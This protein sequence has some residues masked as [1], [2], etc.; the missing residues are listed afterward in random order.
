MKI[1]IP[2][3]ALGLSVGLLAG[4]GGGGS[5]APGTGTVKAS[6]TDSPACGYDHVYV[7][8]TQVSINSKTDGSGNWNDINLTPPKKID[9]LNLTNGALESL[10]QTALP[11]GTYQQLR[12]VLAPNVNGSA[13]LNNSVV[14][15]GQNA[16]VAL[17]TPSAAQS[18]IKV[19]TRAPF[20]VQAGTLV[21]LVLDFNACKS[22]V[23]TG[24]SKG[25]SNNSATGFLLKPVITAVTVVVSGAIDGYVDLAN[26]TTTSNGV[27]VP[28]AMVFAEQGGVIISGTVADST[29]HFILSPL[30]QSSGAGNYDVVIVNAN[31]AT[32]IVNFVPVTAKA[33]TSLSTATAPFTLAASTTGIVN[34]NVNVAANASLDALQTVNG[35]SYGIA[36]T[37][38]DSTT[39]AYDLILPVAAPQVA[40]YSST[41]PITLAPVAA[42]AGQY[43]IK[44]TSSAGN[45]ASSPATVT[46]GGTSTVDF[47]NL[48]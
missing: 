43:T 14:R 22:I 35:L 42:A 45:T 30:E 1:K 47:A 9:L 5:A 12:L 44:A 25:G 23:T 20:T 24:R 36:N 15:S 46:N 27:I 13:T 34:G 48:Q 38:A 3:L 4:C 39:G 2:L 17:K 28:G 40:P 19:N 32:D 8:V 29:G 7:T 16:E 18:G 41:L 11:A 31:K 33:T 37:N 6:L 10:G 21:D 26:A